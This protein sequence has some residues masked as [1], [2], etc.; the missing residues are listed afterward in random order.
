MVGAGKL[1]NNQ[2]DYESVKLMHF[3][4]T[5]IQI[6]VLRGSIYLLTPYSCVKK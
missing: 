3:G 5:F 4:G 1:L 2:H 6:S